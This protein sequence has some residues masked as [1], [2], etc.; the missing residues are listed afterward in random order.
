VAEG[1]S[2][3]A[4]V[5]IVNVDTSVTRDMTGTDGNGRGE[6]TFTSKSGGRGRSLV[7]ERVLGR[8]E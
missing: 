1:G 8:D 3:S 2:V 4:R 7:G 5:L 6:V